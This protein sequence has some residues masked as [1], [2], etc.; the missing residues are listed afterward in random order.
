MSGRILLIASQT[1]RETVRDRVLYC[2]VVFAVLM[3]SVAVL[4]GQV[5]IAIEK[6]MV[7]N[8]G[9]AAL[10]LFG[11]VI[12]ILT[13]IGLVSKEI[14]KRTLYT[15]LSRPVRRWE[16]VLGKYLGTSGTLA[17]NLLLMSVGLFA[18]VFYAAKG[19]E[20]ADLWLFVA[21]YFIALQLLTVSALAIFFSSFSTPLLSAVFSFGLFL[22]GSLYGDLQELARASQGAAGWLITAAT[23]LVPNLSALN[24]AA[25][26]AHGQAVPLSLI[27]H[28]TQYT[29]C[30]IAMVVSGAILVF[31]HRDLR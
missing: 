15:V 11:V 25:T 5:S 22:A 8:L 12:A 21:L 31:D 2:L 23:C 13:G 4:V 7:I 27:V 3:C 18:A 14:E 17:A 6:L 9:L 28:N 16:F 1:F 29:L 26:V 20:K 30:Y 24:V 19:W 10:S